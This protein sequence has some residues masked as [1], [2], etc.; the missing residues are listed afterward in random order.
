MVPT[1]DPKKSGTK[2][3]PPTTAIPTAPTPKPKKSNNA[4]VP[5]L[6]SIGFLLLVAVA[7]LTYNSMNTTRALEQKIA[8]LEEA[9]KLRSELENQ[10]SEAIAELDNLKTD[11]EQINALI[12]Q[13]KAELQAQKSRISS[14][15]RDKRKLDGAR[16]EIEQLKADLQGYIAEIEQLQAEQELLA[17]E[18]TLLKDERDNLNVS[19]KSKLAENE[20]LETARVQLISEK[21]DLA[22]SV[23]LGSVIQVKSVNVTP[24]K[25]RRSGKTATKKSA[26]QTDQLKVCFTTI[27]NEVVQPGA[28]KFFIRIISPQGETLAIDDLGSGVTVDSKT[29]EEVRYTQVAEYDYANDETQLCFLWKPN[30]PFQ[31]GKYDVEI[32]NKGY[33]S[34]KGNFELK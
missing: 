13:Q 16:A 10:Y 18:N 31:K 5:I 23:E 28:E 6:L 19:L 32:Y 2:Q 11:N 29:G 12:D 33:L 26:K 30:M 17:Q 7:W 34:G 22:K 3:S 24:Q 1:N 9:E 21:E 27:V 15:L 25:V 20:E 14:L 4:L 8:Q